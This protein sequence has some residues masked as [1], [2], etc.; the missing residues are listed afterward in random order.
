VSSQ[1][2]ATPPSYVTNFPRRSSTSACYPEAPP[3]QKTRSLSDTTA[4]ARASE[5]YATS[6]ARDYETLHR[7][8]LPPP[9]A[10]PFNE[11]HIP[12]ASLKVPI[13]HNMD[14]NDRSPAL[15]RSMSDVGRP[16]AAN[17]LALKYEC[18][19]C[20]KGFSR[21]SSLKVRNSLFIKNQ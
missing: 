12:S 19:Y 18:E 6:H 13:A 2:L 5:Y 3:Y 11:S 15:Q 16:S 8:A 14:I 9:P 4:L 17:P 1:S 7:H 20:G 10:T 21:P